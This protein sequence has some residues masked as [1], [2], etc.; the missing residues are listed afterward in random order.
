MQMMP[1]PRP[2][3]PEEEFNL[4]NRV[5][6]EE[7]NFE[8][9]RSLLKAF[10][11]KNPAQ[12]LADDAQ[13]WIGRCRRSGPRAWAARQETDYG[14]WPVAALVLVVDPAS[15]HRINPAMAGAVLGLTKMESQVAV[16]LA[17][18]RSVVQI[19]AA[20]GRK[21]S[22]IR[23]H[24]KQMFSKLGLSRQVDLVRLVLSLPGA[25]RVSRLKAR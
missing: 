13:Y 9:A 17:E 5:L 1:A 2:P 21:E 8:K 4:A 11:R 25:Q 22:T 3:G 10:I 18:G 23:T 24:V 20:F 7:R 19:A 12:E 14:I 6:Q 15:R 16:L